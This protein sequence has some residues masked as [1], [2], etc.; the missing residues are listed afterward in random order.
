MDQNEQEVTQ[1]VVP[2]PKL[3]GRAV[4]SA[5]NGARS[6]GRP[7]A[8]LDWEKWNR[9]AFT[10]ASDKDIARALGISRRT[11]K[12]RKADRQAQEFSN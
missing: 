7:R 4:T 10:G 5:V 2:K 1:T 11:L 6:N 8:R 3:D 12:R 9:L